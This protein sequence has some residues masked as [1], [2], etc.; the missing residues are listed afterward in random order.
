VKE[1]REAINI[2]AGVS[3]ADVFHFFDDNVEADLE[4]EEL[5]A[6]AA[7]SEVQDAGT[8]VAEG[9]AWP[10]NVPTTVTTTTTA[11]YQGSTNSGGNQ[12]STIAPSVASSKA[13]TKHQ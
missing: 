5:L 10:V 8:D 2:K 6:D 11:G 4:V 9:V 7:H 13:S 3:D 1:I 12:S